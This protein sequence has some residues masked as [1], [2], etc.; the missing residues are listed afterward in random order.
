MSIVEPLTPY[1]CWERFV[2][3]QTAGE[4]MRLSRTTDV[5]KAVREYIDWHRNVYGGLLRGE[6]SVD[7]EEADELVEKMVEYI[8]R[9]I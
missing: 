1:Q 2:G 8:Q 5:Y 3:S 4:F 9:E 7:N 6:N